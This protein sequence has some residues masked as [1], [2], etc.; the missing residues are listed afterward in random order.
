VASIETIMAASIGWKKPSGPIPPLLRRPNQRSVEMPADSPPL[1][2]LPGSK[3][4]TEEVNLDGAQF[5]L[6]TDGVTE[7]RFGDE[8]PA[9]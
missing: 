9:P 5:V 3:Y 1:G 2:I 8:E 4:E 6:C 7:F